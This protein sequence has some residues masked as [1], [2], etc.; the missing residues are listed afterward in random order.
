MFAVSLLGLVGLLL[1]RPWR[2]GIYL[3]VDL[4]QG[5]NFGGGLG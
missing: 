3:G 2:V 4:G 1:Y 5:V